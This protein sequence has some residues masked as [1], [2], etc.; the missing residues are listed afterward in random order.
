MYLNNKQIIALVFPILFASTLLYFQDEILT[1]MHS[2][3]PTYKN[4]TTSKDF[5]KEVNEYLNINKERQLYN[6]I[7]EHIEKRKATSASWITEKLLYERQNSKKRDKKVTTENNKPTWN[8]QA[9][10]PKQNMVII[11][12]KFVS[13]GS[14]VNSAKIIEIEID[15]VLIKTEKGL[16]WLHLFH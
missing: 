13:K 7:F 9:I 3:L 4:R 1:F 6:D 11:N 2:Q 12:S 16:K 15:S 5:N 8:L 10:F 14:T